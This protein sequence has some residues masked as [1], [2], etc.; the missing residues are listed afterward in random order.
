VVNVMLSHIMVNVIM[1]SIIMLSVV[2]VNVIMLSVVMV[3]VIKVNVIMVNV[4]KVNVIMVNVFTLSFVMMNVVMLS[5]AAPKKG[6]LEVF[7]VIRSSRKR[8]AEQEIKY[9]NNLEAKKINTGVVFKR[10]R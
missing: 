3:N 7:K 2:M 5:V 8:I 9:E 10:L 4:I 6:G 1:L